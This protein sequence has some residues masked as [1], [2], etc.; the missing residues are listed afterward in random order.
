[1][2]VVLLFR[3]YALYDKSRRILALML[4]A[5]CIGTAVTTVDFQLDGF[6]AVPHGS[7]VGSFEHSQ[8]QRGNNV[9]HFHPGVYDKRL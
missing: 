1:M 7:E 5:V 3:T 4:S 8:C 9:P 6:L 2:T